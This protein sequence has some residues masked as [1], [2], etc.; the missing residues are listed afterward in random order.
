MHFD[1]QSSFLRNPFLENLQR[2][3]LNF[4]H[5]FESGSNVNPETPNL[6]RPAVGGPSQGRPG[7]F[8]AVIKSCN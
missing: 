4:L 6:Q 7:F 8:F 1:S 2:P 3:P 5:E